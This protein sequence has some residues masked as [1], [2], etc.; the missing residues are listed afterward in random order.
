[1]YIYIYTFIYIHLYIHLYIYILGAVDESQE[2][3]S[4]VGYRRFERMVKSKQCLI[5]KRRYL[6]LPSQVVGI[7]KIDWLAQCQDIVTGWD[8]RYWCFW[9]G[10]PVWQHYKV[11]M[12]VHWHK[13]VR[14]LT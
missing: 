5:K 9:S 6:S 11:T 10:F 1:M 14:I 12:S 7:I 8:I 3:R 2:H 4:R 13:S